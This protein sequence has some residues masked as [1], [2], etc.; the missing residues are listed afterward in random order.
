[1]NSKLIDYHIHPG[2]SVDAEGCIRDFV[3]R[4]IEMR[5]S[6][7]CFTTHVDLNHARKVWDLF[8]KMNGEYVRFDYDIMSYYIDDVKNNTEEFKDRID[9]KCGVEISYGHHFEDLISDLLDS[10]DF[11]FVLGAVHCL[12]NVS[13]T[14]SKEAFGYFSG[15]SSRELCEKYYKSLYSLV[16]SGLFKTVA[17]ID[18]YKKYGLAYYGPGILEAHHGLLSP[19]LKLMGEKGVGFEINTSAIRKGHKEFY[20]SNQIIKEA[21]RFGVNLHSIGSDA[22]KPEQVGFMIEKAFDLAS[23]IGFK[24]RR[25]DQ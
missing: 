4:A 12:D 11:D 9:I 19:V 5:L 10:F 20:P 8:M 18:C 21:F 25:I 6:S 13:I 22:H 3:L 24:I 2:Y 23:D 16:D 1:M 15:T 14:A 7:I 17:H